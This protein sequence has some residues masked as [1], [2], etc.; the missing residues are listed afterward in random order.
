MRE[1][2]AV[3]LNQVCSS[4]TAKGNST[5]HKLCIVPGVQQLTTIRHYYNFPWTTEKCGLM[6][7]GFFVVYGI[8]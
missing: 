7:P 6:D 8:T 1:Y 5:K 4:L 2:I 3:V